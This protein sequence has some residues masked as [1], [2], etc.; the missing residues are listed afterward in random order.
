MDP[1]RLAHELHYTSL[2]GERPRGR[3]GRDA[4]NLHGR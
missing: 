4:I 3:P 2:K 1:Q